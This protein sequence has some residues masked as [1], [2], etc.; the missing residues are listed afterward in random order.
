MASA[1]HIN[2]GCT[3]YD[4]EWGVGEC[5]FIDRDSIVP[6]PPETISTPRPMA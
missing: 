6:I 5:G 2:S 1:N 3:P 4:G